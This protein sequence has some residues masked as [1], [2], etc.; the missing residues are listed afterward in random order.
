MKKSLLV[1]SI[2]AVLSLAACGVKGL[3]DAVN[4]GEAVGNLGNEVVLQ[5]PIKEMAF[6]SLSTYKALNAETGS[7]DVPADDTGT[8]NSEESELDLVDRYYAIYKS[9]MADS[10]LTVKTYESTLEGYAYVA[11]ISSKDVEGNE[12]IYSLYFNEEAVTNDDLDEDEQEDVTDAEE[13]ASSNESEGQSPEQKRAHGDHE[14]DDHEDY[15]DTRTYV[16][17]TGLL[18]DGATQTEVKGLRINDE[19]YGSEELMFRAKLSE[20]GFIRVHTYSDTETQYLS[21]MKV[22]DHQLTQLARIIQES[23]DGFNYTSILQYTGESF[24]RYS[25][26]T[27]IDEETGDKYIDIRYVNNLEQGHILIHVIVAEDGTETLE[28]QFDNGHHYHGNGHGDHEHDNDEENHGGHHGG[29]GDDSEEELPD[30]EE[31]SD[32]EVVTPEVEEHNHR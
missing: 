18:D 30:D 17:F 7:E 28:Y 2:A 11:V 22:E 5:A 24:S 9:I 13:D 29:H 20:T 12:A 32:E 1:L 14:H 10:L 4:N 21:L 15:V 23:Y 19:T 27:F 25:F 6:A 3:D 8:T 26:R 16:R 31:T